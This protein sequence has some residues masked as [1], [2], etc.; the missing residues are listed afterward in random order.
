M[1]LRFR[2]KGGERERE[3]ERRERE[4][5]KRERERERETWSSEK[6]ADQMVGGFMVGVA[7]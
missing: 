6:P 2:R 3:R 4:R 7:M 5:E 1:Q